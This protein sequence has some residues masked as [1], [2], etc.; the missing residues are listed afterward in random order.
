[1]NK[2]CRLNITNYKC[3]QNS[4]MTFKDI[5]IIVGKNN[6]GK[7]TIIETLRLVAWAGKKSKS[8]NRYV[9][10]PPDFNFGLS[11]KGIELNVEKL[12]IDLRGS[13]YYYNNSI[14][15]IK[16]FF[17]DKSSIEVNIKEGIV[18]AVFYDCNNQIVKNVSKARQL[19]FDSIGILPQIGLIKENEKLLSDK[20]IISDRETY[21]SSRHFRNEIKLYKNEYFESFKALSEESW[22]DLMIDDLCYNL[23][24]SE[25]IHLYIQDNRFTAEIGLMGSGLQMW[26]QVIW[27]I[28]RSQGQTTL[29]LD[30]PDIYMHPDLQRKLLHILKLR[31][32]Q[33]IIATHS[34]EI[35]SEVEPKNIITIDKENQCMKYA[36]SNVAVQ[37]IIDNIGSVHNLSLLRLSNSGK[38]IF[39]EG[40]DIKILSKFYEVLYPGKYNPIN[41]LPVVSLGGF[42]R[43]NEAYGAAKLFFEQTGGSFKTFCILDR[44]Y[45][46]DEF[47]EDKLKQAKIN[48][49]H[50]HI[51]S[52]KEIE[53]FI[54]I[55]QAIFRITKR[56]DNEYES[57]IGKLSELV[58]TF[59]ERIQDQITA[60][61]FEYK[62]SQ[63]VD[64]SVC[65]SIA[66]DIMNENWTSIE[67]KLSLVNGKLMISKINDWMKLNYKKSCSMEKIIAN[68]RKEEVNDEIKYIIK[69][70]TE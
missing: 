19:D 30:E 51:W 59:K 66:R 18:F 45:Y 4:Y 39:V 41:T 36:D 56:P 20:T 69:E 54:L 68:I 49:L 14:S 10:A 50:L 64:L 67:N 28:C 22:E 11:K 29:I 48:N 44:D 55:P 24:E 5:T 35:I 31:F 17:K 1:M 6:A 16:A 61:L 47:L 26:L 2:L 33:V 25:N 32:S 37:K 3:F 34:V 43:L 15:V 57:F 60:K 13:G 53:N 58:D 12:R 9:Y 62:K 52:K 38:C 27:F 21:L 65:L 46:A 42:S 23:H 70:L 7:S 63:G 40:K 8:T